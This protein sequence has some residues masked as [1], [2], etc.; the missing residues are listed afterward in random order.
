MRRN[1]PIPKF[2]DLVQESIS[3][4]EEH[5]SKHDP[6]FN[7]LKRYLGIEYDR[8]GLPPN[9]RFLQALYYS[10]E[11]DTIQGRSLSGFERIER[12]ALRIEENVF[13]SRRIAMTRLLGENMEHASLYH[14]TESSATCKN[15]HTNLSSNGR[16]QT[17]FRFFGQKKSFKVHIS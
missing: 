14:C 15:L 7:K 5:V 16:P 13:K 4:L 6:E 17:D 8:H 3:N 9:F 2:S 1:S 10:P 11:P 12:A